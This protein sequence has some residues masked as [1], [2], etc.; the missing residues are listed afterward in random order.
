MIIQETSSIEYGIVVAVVSM[1]FNFVMQYDYH[2]TD[3]FCMTTE[4]KMG[5]WYHGYLNCESII[6]YFIYVAT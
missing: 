1:K 6:Y 5:N 3:I 2:Y 4:L